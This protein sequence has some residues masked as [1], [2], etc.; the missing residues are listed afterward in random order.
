M[1]SYC[2]QY[3]IFQFILSIS[4]SVSNIPTTQTL[5]CGIVAIGCYWQKNVLKSHQM[6]ANSSNGLQM[7]MSQMSIMNSNSQIADSALSSNNSQIHGM[8]VQPI[9]ELLTQVGRF[10]LLYDISI[11]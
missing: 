4:Y 1:R 10:H 6:F 11:N 7:H 3:A 5:K 9:V 2:N 8:N